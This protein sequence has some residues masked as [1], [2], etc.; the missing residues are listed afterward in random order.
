MPRAK[1][2]QKILVGL[3]QAVDAEQ[4]LALAA[5][6]APPGK[7]IAVLHIIEVPPATPL[8]AN[9]SALDAPGQAVAR[10]VKRVA[11]KY[12]RRKF[13]VR[14][15]RARD[16]GRTV[17]DELKEGRF[18]L[19]VLGYHHKRSLTELLLGTTARYLAE[20][21]PCRLVMNIPPSR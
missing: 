7:T 9:S 4:L 18:D 17:V 13:T 3:K 20:H 2:V 14:I 15:L 21:A 19:A 16:T 11:R 6:L 12:P 1:R 5:Q 8:D 10:A